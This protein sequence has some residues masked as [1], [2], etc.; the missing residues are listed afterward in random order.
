MDMRKTKKLIF[1]IGAGASKAIA[2]EE[3]PAMND[4]FHIA[5]NFARQDENIKTTLDS[6]ESYGLLQNKEVNL[7][8]V[9][10]H[11]MKLPRNHD[12]PWERP[13]DGLL[14]TLHKIFYILNEKYRPEPFIRCLE[15]VRHFLNSSAT[16]ISFNYD[17]FLERSLNEILNWKTCFGY[18][19]N[20]LVGFIESPQADKAQSDKSI[21]DEVYAW[22]MEE[23]D[24]AYPQKKATRP[25][26]EI[27][28][29][30]KPHGSLNWFI[31]PS[32]KP[33]AWIPNCTGFLLMGPNKETPSISK[34]WN[35]STVNT[36]KGEFKRKK[37]YIGS[38]LP[39]I[40]PPGRKFAEKRKVKVFQK[41][42]EA[43]I[44]ELTEAS[45]LVIIGWSMS[46]FD[47]HYK[48]LFKEVIE[49]RKSQKLSKLAVC[50]FQRS[51]EFYEKFKRLLPHEVFLS[52][53]EGFG[54]DESIK[55]LRAAIT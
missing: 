54:S 18:S 12:N 35:Y 45:V 24:K 23:Y 1:I 49:R 10:E 13:Y 14:L 11:T 25:V 46:G 28:V 52:C 42:N 38:I 2:P 48:Q 3:I 36:V 31:H 9:L 8:Y 51:P 40:I 43:V 5:K 16:F 37:S 22:G 41:I 17:V 30:L 55:L 53:N 4:F 32:K 21:C 29:V 39:A 50:D 34:S 26:N 19:P 47:K 27:P 7:E 33:H 20:P 6:L 44:Q 15:P